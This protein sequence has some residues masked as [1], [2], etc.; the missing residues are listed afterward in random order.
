MADKKEIMTIAREVIAGDWGSG[1]KRKKALIN[2]G[3]DYNIVQKEVNRLLSCRELIIQNIKAWATKIANSHKY[4][5][6]AYTEPY[7]H[8]CAVCHPHDGKNKG[9]QCIGWA[10]ACWHHGGLP[11]PCG[12]GTI[13]NSICE[14]ILKAKTDAEALTIAQKAL[15]LKD[16]QVIRNNGKAIPK[17]KMKPGDIA[18]I[19][20]NND[21]Y[22]HTYLVMS[23]E[24][25][26][27][28]TRVDGFKNDIS[29]N[30]AFKG[31]YVDGAKVVIRYTGNGFV[32]PEKKSVDEL[33]H[34]VIDGLWGN[35]E[36]RKT[37]LTECKYDYDAV[38]KRVN[39]ILSK[40]TY[41]G[42][43]PTTQLV[44]TNAE[45]IE[46]TIK[47]A[48]WIASDNDF[49]YGYTNKKVTPWKP[50]AHHN[51]CYFCKTQP[52]SKKGIVDYEH[53]YCCNPFVGA[54]WA[55]GGCV[56]KALELCRR[57][58]SWDFGKGQGYDASK[59]FDKLGHP[60]KSKLKAGDVLCR[61]GH[62]ALYIGNGKLVEAGN[63]DDNI[64]HSAGWNKSISVKTMSDSRY[65]GFKRVYRFNSSVNTNCVMRHGEVSKRV[66]QWQAFLDW[67]Y[68][69]KVGKADGYY[70]D[71]TLKWTKK[72]Q[73][74]YFGKKEAD[75]LIGDK[76][77]AKAKTA[78]K[79]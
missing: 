72:F 55:H 12:C 21:V 32:A 25:I 31:R 53:T 43:L 3:Y 59:L 33:A 20:V 17:S 56:P 39:E 36:S 48:K 5:Y 65:K 66:A 57:C 67:Y 68:D 45:V 63:G 58:S 77:L 42:I 4:K 41:P 19:F 76:T 78:K 44:K 10:I 40:D 28:S 22:Q 23:D 2:A 46:D 24:Y 69:G 9:W 26:S 74:E 11:I 13:N 49:H 52:K 35:G 70:G 14:K 50:N 62:V 79:K 75:G 71:N 34:E 16:I 38:Q 7:G 15:K 60:E 51:G 1:E 54:A 27:D 30:R 29:V 61:D 18:L 6:I 37:A 64:R 73:E 8:E 47:W